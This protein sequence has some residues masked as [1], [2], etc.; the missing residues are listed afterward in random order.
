VNSYERVVCV[1]P[2]F[3]AATTIESVVRALRSS[4]PG[5]AV[6]VVNDGSTDATPAA[7]RG[8]ADAVLSFRQNRG[9]GAALRLGFDAALRRGAERVLTIDADGQHDPASAPA[10]LDALTRSD[11]AIGTRARSGTAMPIGR[12]LTNHLASSAVSAIAHTSIADPQSGFR[13]FRRLV[14]EQVKGVGQRYEFETDL[15]IRAAAAGF[16]IVDVP[17]ATSYGAH[18]HFR[19][20]A[21]S[22]SVVRTIWRHRARASAAPSSGADS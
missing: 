20:L 2:A 8:C 19:P 7:A 16:R 1:I 14:L 4:V 3:Q 11:V 17:V 9:K 21:D 18:S 6:I 12:R 15:L 13:A 10:L 22:L 5:A